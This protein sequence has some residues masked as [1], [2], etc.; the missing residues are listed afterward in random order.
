M[1]FARTRH[2]VVDESICREVGDCF[3]WRGWNGYTCLG[4]KVVFLILVQTM[5]RAESMGSQ[6]ISGGYTEKLPKYGMR[7]IINRKLER[8]KTTIFTDAC[9]NTYSVKC[10]GEHNRENQLCQKKKKKIELGF[11]THCFSCTPQWNFVLAAH[12]H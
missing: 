11:T 5:G 7:P 1:G 2:K 4:G 9:I 12:R 3:V 6:L 10:S 8:K